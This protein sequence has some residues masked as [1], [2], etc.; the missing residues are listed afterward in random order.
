MNH[1]KGKRERSPWTL[2]ETKGVI[3][4]TTASRLAT[5]LTLSGKVHVF[6]L[7]TQTTHKKDTNVSAK[8]IF[9]KTTIKLG[10]SLSQIKKKSKKNREGVQEIQ[11][12][13]ETQ[14]RGEGIHEISGGKKYSVQMGIGGP[15]SREW[16]LLEGKQPCRA[17]C[18]KKKWQSLYRK[19]K[20]LIFLSARKK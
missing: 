19:T 15:R 10:L 9:C 1:Q 7:Y 3:L 12:K 6:Q 4:T 2:P 11:G 8:N 17:L 13:M 14:S 20:A 5:A 16:H 18:T